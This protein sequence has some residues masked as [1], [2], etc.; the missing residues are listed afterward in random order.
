MVACDGAL[1]C[2]V[3]V[4]IGGVY[5]GIR[6]YDIILFHIQVGHGFCH[7]RGNAV[8]F[9][10]CRL[11][12]FAVCADFKGDIRCIGVCLHHTCTVY[13]DFAFSRIRHA[14]RPDG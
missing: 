9:L 5:G 13:V 12:C 11:R 14:R 3:I 2:F 7:C 6:R 10:L 4:A 1:A 8:V